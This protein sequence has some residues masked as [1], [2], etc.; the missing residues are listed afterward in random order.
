MCLHTLVPTGAF[1]DLVEAFAQR[2]TGDAQAIDGAG[3]GFDQVASAQFDRVDAKVMR[4]LIH[5]YFHRTAR[6]CCAMTALGTTRWLVG[7]ETHTFKL[8]AG[9]LIRHRL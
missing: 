5:M 3:I 2:T 7:E 4:K 8:V 1:D 6:L 9:Q